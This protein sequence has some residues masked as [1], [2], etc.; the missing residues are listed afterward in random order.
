MDKG[1]GHLSVALVFLHYPIQS[2]FFINP[3][4]L[5]TLTTFTNY[6]FIVQELDKPLDIFLMPCNLKDLTCNHEILFEQIE[7]YKCE[8]LVHV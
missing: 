7:P 4:S 8:L 5:S 6:P 1:N 2:N 3:L